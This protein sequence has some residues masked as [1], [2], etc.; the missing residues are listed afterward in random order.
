M[1]TALITGASSGL[2][3]ELAEMLA[4]EGYALILVAR[5]LDRMEALAK[6]LRVPVKIIC[7]DLGTRDGLNTVFERTA[8]DR[9]DL[10]V[11]NA[12]FGVYGEFDKTDL[13]RD[14][15]M[16]DVNCKAL[17]AMTKHFLPRMIAQDSGTVLNVASVAGFL[18]GPMMA[19]YYATKSYVL[20]LTKSVAGELRHMGS[21]VRVCAICPGP[22]DTE[23]NSVANVRFALKG[24]DCKTVAKAALDGVRRG[25]TVI[26]PG[27][28]VKLTKFGI[29]LAPDALVSQI[30]LRMQ[31]KK[32]VQ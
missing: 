30:C 27:L 26:Y 4:T 12:G 3:S 6:T 18:I 21:R 8:D 17:H 14:L 7:A 5:R 9:I 13:D 23:F 2:G 24:M 1:K 11:N 31:L 15:E 28:L 29:R 19:T 16:I 10:L 32:K 20:T 22:F 25:K